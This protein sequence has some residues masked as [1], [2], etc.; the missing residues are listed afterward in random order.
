VDMYLPC[1]HLLKVNGDNQG[2]ESVYGCTS[3]TQVTASQCVRCQ[4]YQMRSGT[5]TPASLGLLPPP[6]ECKQP[7]TMV[8]DRYGRP[9]RV[10]DL[11]W[12]AQAFLVLGGPSLKTFPLERLAARGVLVISTNNC[13]AI[14]PPSVRPHVWIHTDPPHKFHDSIWRD[15][16]I[17]KFTP[18]REWNPGRR[19]KKC[20]R[21]RTDNG[22]LE[23]VP[24]LPSRDCPGVFGYDRNSAFDPAN[25]LFEPS[26]NRGNDVQHSEGGKEFNGSAK[27]INTMYSALRL[28]FYLGIRT[29]Y[30]LGCDFRMTSN[31]PYSFNQGKGDPGVRSNNGAYLAMCL[32]FDRLQKHFLENQFF[33]YNCTPG[34]Q[35]WSFPEMSFD[36]ALRRSTEH[37]EEKLDCRGW[38]DPLPGPKQ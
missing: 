5:I 26:I 37:F 4:E 14:L 7:D 17:L 6:A 29:V 15:P 20:I 35:L 25:F 23:K 33:V 1:V 36:E 12:G 30:L 32:N 27:G 38:Y 18:I 9:A 10:A 28:A 3:H 34:S 22:E 21:H 16:A 31:S 2:R 11:F 24:G 8:V 19:D 13:P